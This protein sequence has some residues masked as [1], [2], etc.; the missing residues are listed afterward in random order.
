MVRSVH[1][2]RSIFMTL[3][4]RV[5]S[6]DHLETNR[7]LSPDLLVQSG[8]DLALWIT[9]MDSMIP[10][11]VCPMKGSVGEEDTWLSWYH[12]SVSDEQEHFKLQCAATAGPLFY[13][14][15]VTISR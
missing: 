9:S 2:N 5:C 6:P 14:A 1:L 8:E 4:F 11:N 7:D 13:S 10:L 12:F 15:S 3:F